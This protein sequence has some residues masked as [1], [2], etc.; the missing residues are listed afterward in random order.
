MKLTACLRQPRLLATFL[1]VAIL[2]PP[3][4]AAE[5]RASQGSG[6][7]DVIELGSAEFESTAQVPAAAG[8][9]VY[10]HV[11]IT[12]KT[13]QDVVKKINEGIA[14]G[15]YRSPFRNNKE[16]MDM[17]FGSRPGSFEIEFLGLNKESRF[18]YFFEEQLKKVK[19]D[20]AIPSGLSRRTNELAKKTKSL[21][22]QTIKPNNFEGSKIVYEQG[23]KGGCIAF[24]GSTKLGNQLV[25]KVIFSDQE[26]PIYEAMRRVLNEEDSSRRVPVIEKGDF[27]DIVKSAQKK[28][29]LISKE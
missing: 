20:P 11:R 19:T 14:S 17:A 2:C 16:F 28:K 10:M 18:Y 7:G 4:F 25:G 29:I 23:L 9:N 12:L 22:Y 8:G 5:K 6:G 3:V 1:G 27:D 21:L 13:S 24:F 26:E 15:R